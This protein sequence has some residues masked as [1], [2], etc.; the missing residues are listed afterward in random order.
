[1]SY[2]SARSS[3]STTSRRGISLALMILGFVAL[4]GAFRW[5][6]NRNAPAPATVSLTVFGGQALVTR[7]DAGAGSPLQAGD[8]TTL[9]RGD[10]VR[11]G[12]QARAKLTFSGGETMELG[13]ETRLT[14][15]DLYQSSVSRALVAVLALHEGKT[16]TRIRHLLLQGMRFEVETPVVTVQVRG[17]VFE[18]DV[19][20]RERT[21]VAAYAGVVSVSMGE[22]A[23]ELQ[24]GQAV[25]ARLGQAL[26]AIAVSQTPPLEAGEA[27][28][29]VGGALVISP[30]RG[31]PAATAPPSGRATL[32]DRDKTLF[33][34]TTVPTHPS[35][36]VVL[37]EVKQG[38]TLY[39]IAR[40]FGISWEAIWDANKDVLKKP[41][42]LRVGQSLRIPQ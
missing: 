10:E 40:Q 39:S 17:T 42:L 12:P 33:P 18:C 27:L 4:L 8:T 13:G 22:Q 3:N 14:I 38:D 21:Y 19:P 16:L 5:L 15:L 25:E 11:T 24:A 35:G 26:V 1:M 36:Q 29:E 20:S 23:I 2:Y 37:Y 34:V 9:Q 28:P 7:A 31:T 30:A 41:E 6:Q 32:T